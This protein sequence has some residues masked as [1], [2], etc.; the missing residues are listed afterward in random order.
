[1]LFGRGRL[2]VNV[3]WRKA[4]DGAPLFTDWTVYRSAN[5]DERF[6]VANELGEQPGPRPWSNGKAR[7]DVSG[8]IYGCQPLR[9]F[10]AG[11]EPGEPGPLFDSTCKVVCCSPT[12]INYWNG[13]A[14][15]DKIL[16]T[17]QQSGS[18][19]CGIDGIELVLERQ[20]LRSEWLFEDLRFSLCFPGM[21]VSLLRTGT[22][23]TDWE[24]HVGFVQLPS[25][26]RLNVMPL[27]ASSTSPFFMVFFEVAFV[28]DYWTLPVQAILTPL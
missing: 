24:L 12:Q 4:N 21:L 16:C 17:F 25:S 15:P 23:S 10:E 5:W 3:R 26:V 11:L 2:P 13:F 19:F 8:N 28:T 1:M 22:G 7:P 9:W 20:P 14:I 27:T 18:P 6:C